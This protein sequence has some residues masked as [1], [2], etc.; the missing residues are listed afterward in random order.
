MHFCELHARLRLARGLVGSTCLLRT[1]SKTN[2]SQENGFVLVHTRVREQQRGIVEGN[3][4]RGLDE[5]VTM[6]DKE[7]DKRLAHL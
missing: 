4:G 1:K 3:H 5:R 2:L 7:V 6:V